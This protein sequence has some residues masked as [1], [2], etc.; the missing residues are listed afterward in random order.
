MSELFQTD[1]LK[2][3]SLIIIIIITIIIIII[4]ICAKYINRVGFFC[5]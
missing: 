1:L 4:I 3:M 5:F 2:K